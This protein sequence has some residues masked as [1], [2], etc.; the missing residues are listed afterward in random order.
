MI[1]PGD[2]SAR[3]LL[4]SADCEV[5]THQEQMLNPCADAQ[6][7]SSLP[8]AVLSVVFADWWGVRRQQVAHLCWRQ[9]TER[10]SSRGPA[11]NAAM[12]QPHSPVPPWQVVPSGTT[13]QT[14]SAPSAP[15]SWPPLRNLSMKAQFRAAKDMN[16][17]ES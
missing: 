8:L 4:Q 1:L 3:D 9:P 10:P 7:P 14:A 11:A 17:G 12:L 13:I 5:D 16:R 6:Q 15:M 2:E